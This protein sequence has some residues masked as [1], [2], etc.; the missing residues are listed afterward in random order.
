[1]WN[2]AR[3][4][5]KPGFDFHELRHTHETWM[6]EDGTPEVLRNARMGHKSAKMSQHYSHVTADMEETLVKNL[7]QRWEDS[8]VAAGVGHWRELWPVQRSGQ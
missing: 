2:P 3:E 6:E 7:T 4:R 5:V 1:M 8:L